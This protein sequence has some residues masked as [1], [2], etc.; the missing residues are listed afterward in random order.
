MQGTREDLKGVYERG[1]GQEKENSSGAAHGDR[2][3]WLWLEVWDRREQNSLS[4]Q[5]VLE[6]VS[7]IYLSPGKMQVLESSRDWLLEA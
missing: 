4:C 7:Q 5:E 6:E 2:C 1:S 3:Q